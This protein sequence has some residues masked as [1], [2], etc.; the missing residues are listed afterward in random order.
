MLTRPN[1]M[2]W[3]ADDNS[4][5]GQNPPAKPDGEKP[6]ASGEQL[7]DWINDPAKVMQEIKKLRDEAASYRS[8]RNQERD[9]L[10]A[11]QKMLDERLPK[12]EMPSEEKD[13]LKQMMARM[14]AFEAQQR[15]A[16]ET[17]AKERMDALKMRVA[18]EILGDKVQGENKAQVLA[19]LAHRLNGQTEEELR[20]DAQTFAALMPAPNPQWKN[21]TNPASP[22]GQ[23]V[24]ETDQQRLARIRRGGAKTSF[25]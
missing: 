3:Q 10:A 25:T 1:T 17:A 14:E 12:P 2:L 21:N 20:Q 13:P 22:G 24:G 6:N 18:T 19:S 11:F 9:S 4:L 16:L 7:P 8:Q 15:T 23:P 5:G